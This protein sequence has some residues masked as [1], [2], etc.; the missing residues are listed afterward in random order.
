MRPIARWLFVEVLGLAP[1]AAGGQS[2]W[3][4]LVVSPEMRCAAYDS[5]DYQYSPSLVR[6]VIA[7]MG[8][9]IYGP[10]TGRTFQRPTETEV[11]SAFG[12]LLAVC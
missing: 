4:G 5:E 9:R 3:W 11:G 1:P 2:T 10:Y 7:A 8:G 6:A 12:G